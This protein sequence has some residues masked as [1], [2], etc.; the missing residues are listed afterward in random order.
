MLKTVENSRAKKTAGLAV[1]YRAGDSE[2]FGT[3]PAHCKLNPSGKGCGGNEIDTEYLDALMNAKPSRGISFG[4]THFDPLFWSHK[5]GQNKTVLNYSADT[6]AEAFVV[7]SNKIAPVVTV[8][9]PDFWTSDDASQQYR[10]IDRNDMSAPPVKV[11]RCPEEY[12]AARGCADCGNGKPLCARLDRN[13]IIGFTAHGAAAH[14]AA[15][16]D[17]GGCYASNGPAALQWGATAKQIQT[18]TDS[19][20]LSDFIKELPPRSIIRHHVAGDIGL[21]TRA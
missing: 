17:P 8:V 3:C 14:K 2:K 11:N 20:K 6:L 1:T 7:H 21:D 4:Y 19:E 16:D 10:F 9:K 5:L 18:Q 12:G 15:T 13:F